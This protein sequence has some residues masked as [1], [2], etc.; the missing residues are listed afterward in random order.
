MKNKLLMSTLAGVIGATTILHPVDAASDKDQ[1]SKLKKEKAALQKEVKTLKSQKAKLYSDHKSLKSKYS[2]LDKSYQ[3]VSKENK[4]LKDKVK[5]LSQGYQLLETKKQL[6]WN[7]DLVNKSYKATPSLLLLKNTP[8]IPLDLAARL[9]NLPLKS[10]SSSFELGVPKNGVSLSTLKHE[11]SSFEN[12]LYNRTIEVR[13]KTS[14]SNIIFDQYNVL[15]SLDPSAIYYLNNNFT[16][17]ETDVL[18]TP[19]DVANK[20]SL[21]G[22]NGHS[23]T[24]KILDAK[25]KKIL[26]EYDLIHDEDPVHIKLDVRGVDGIQFMIDSTYESSSATLSNPLL[27]K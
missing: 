17:F 27:T 11:K 25:T 2:K 16:T 8:Y 24:F 15:S 23:L 14:V 10:T 12:V 13:G 22:R 18:V 7:G 20:L 21:Y 9:N 26:A 1:I 19:T 4:L 3:A 5:T 6:L